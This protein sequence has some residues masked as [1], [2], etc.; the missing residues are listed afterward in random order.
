V[1]ERDSSQWSPLLQ[2]SQVQE[3]E[4]RMASNGDKDVY[5]H[6]LQL[7]RDVTCKDNGRAALR[8]LSGTMGEMR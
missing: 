6:A 1:A 8:V 3:D 4:Q 5:G 2:T 7:I